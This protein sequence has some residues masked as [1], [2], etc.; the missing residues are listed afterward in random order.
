MLELNTA[1]PSILTEER[2]WYPDLVLSMNIVGEKGGGEGEV[3]E[4]AFI[5]IADPLGLA[6]MW[7]KLT[8]RAAAFQVPLRL[9]LKVLAIAKDPV[10]SSVIAA[11][12]F[13]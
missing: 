1:P 13:I 8:A 2:T 11:V 3:G 5:E 9:L 4:R 12:P 6:V 10:R 7:L